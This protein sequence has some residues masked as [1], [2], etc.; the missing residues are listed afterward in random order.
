VTL[1][2]EA[3][4]PNSFAGVGFKLQPV[5]LVTGLVNNV[6]DVNAGDYTATIYWGDGQTS[7]GF[8]CVQPP[9]TQPN[10]LLIKGSHI[11]ASAQ[12][13]Y[14][15]SVNVVGPQG[16][17]AFSQT[18]SCNVFNMPFATP[19]PGIDPPA[20]SGGPMAPGDDN[21]SVMGTNE[22]SAYAGVETTQ[23]V[24][25]VIAVINGE[26]DTSPSDYGAFINWGDGAAWDHNP[27]IE[28][29]GTSSVVLPVQG[30][31]TYASPGTYNVTVYGIGPDGISEALKTTSVTVNPVPV[32]VGVPTNAYSNQIA[33]DQPL[34]DDAATTANDNR[35][36]QEAIDNSFPSI[37]E[38]YQNNYEPAD[39]TPDLADP[40][41]DPFS[42]PFA[43]A[44]QLLKALEDAGVKIGQ[45]IEK[46]LPFISETLKD[47]LPQDTSQVVI[48]A[49]NAGVP[50]AALAMEKLQAGLDAFS[51]NDP[52]AVAGQPVSGAVV[53]GNIFRGQGPVVQ[54][55]IA[56]GDLPAN[57][58]ATSAAFALGT[59]QISANFAGTPGADLANQIRAVK[60]ADSAF[61][62]SGD[63]PHAY[64][65]ALSEAE[66][67]LPMLS[68]MA[69]SDPN[70]NV[71]W[72]SPNV[73]PADAIAADAI[74]RGVPVENV[75]NG[76]IAQA[77]RTL[78]QSLGAAYA[79]AGFSGVLPAAG[80]APLLQGGGS[81]DTY[82]IGGWDAE[83]AGGTVRFQNGQFFQAVDVNGVI[84]YVTGAGDSTQLPGFSYY[85][86]LNTTG[87]SLG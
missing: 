62:A 41:S 65:A 78:P 12:L 49:T 2:G 52:Y 24:A 11:Y 35:D 60:F 33:K 83:S 47:F 74:L 1:A 18:S 46:I 86:V 4:L 48:D 14:P 58:T 38:G 57:F 44:G 23:D 22:L 6:A 56:D 79:G 63:K 25:S 67:D 45:G 13:N 84:N 28:P 40:Q 10:S 66:T 70:L 32:G 87:V 3:S 85:R 36:I 53:L 19:G 81:G 51:K 27:T 8:V 43:S 34:L 77:N 37:A 71:S 31:H 64:R 54:A 26:L 17:T 68:S 39:L 59:T 42:G 61:I 9:T 80:V 55:L 72:L 16:Y 76:L 75:L 73:A 82:L 30:T 15:I 7:P 21:F 20:A 29:V 50:N 5:A 69:P